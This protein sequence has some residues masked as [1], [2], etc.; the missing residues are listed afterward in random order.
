MSTA[1]VERALATAHRAF[2]AWRDVRF[3]TR[4][5]RASCAAARPSSREP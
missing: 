5:Q 1:D 4:T 3:A 2:G